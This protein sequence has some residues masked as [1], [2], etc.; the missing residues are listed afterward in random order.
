MQ[1]NT[2]PTIQNGWPGQI[3]IVQICGIAVQRSQS[4]SNDDGAK[5]TDKFIR[6]RGS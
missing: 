6:E 5:Y 3:K 1:S 4:F 2:S